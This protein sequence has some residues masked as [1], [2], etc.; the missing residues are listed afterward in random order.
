MKLFWQVILV[1]NTVLRRDCSAG[2]YNV[3][4]NSHG[5]RVGHRNHTPS[6]S[7]DFVDE[8]RLG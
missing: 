3:P 1:Y 4:G 6:D 8:L 5:V 7:P 2:T